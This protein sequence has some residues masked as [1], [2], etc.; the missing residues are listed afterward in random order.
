[1]PAVPFSTK[2]VAGL[3]EELSGALLEPGDPAY[4]DA[5]RVHNGLI[6]RHPALIARCRTVNDIAAA[7]RF[8]R[9]HGLEVAV[10]GGG[11]NVA[12]RATVD[13]GL[14][15][16]LSMMREVRVDPERRLGVAQGGVTWA[17]LTEATQGHGLATTG[18]V[19]SSTGVA[20][21]T[22]GGGWGWLQG[23]H[24]LSVDN[25]ESVEM[26]LADGTVVTAGEG[27]NPD[28][29]WAVRG[30]GA[31]FG[32]VASFTFRLHPVGPTVVGGMVLHPFEH[33]CEVLGF[34]RDV[35]ESLPDELTLGAG[36]IH[37][38]DGS[39][40]KLAAILAG[41]CGPV[42]EGLEA[43][44]PL[45]D[46]GSPVMDALG[47]MPYEDLNRMLDDAYP[48]GALNYWKSGFLSGL[49]DDAID[50]A[51]DAFARCPVPMGQ[52]ILEMWHGATR[53]VAPD[54]TAYPHRKGGHNVVVL[55]EWMDA[56]DTEAGI[57]WARETYAALGP[58]LTG[59]GYVNYMSEGDRAEVA[60]AYGANHPRLAAL[61]A[62]Y[63]PDNL[64]HLNHNIRP[65]A[66]A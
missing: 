13:G 44:Q 51:I 56:A 28:L 62:K 33:A 65:K 37:A 3:D 41:W 32:V 50:T 35:A 2:A 39:G 34:Y 49:G 66:R 46:H 17:E 43:V 5:R 20:G 36:L 21:L 12:G 14:V 52:V 1:M 45:K 9:D 15:I 31:N 8:G 61:K 42:E 7:V 30:A 64:F 10:R 4:D 40:A 16:D 48:R 19:V 27:E 55:S 54:A 26:V 63:D 59:G 24:G 47:P 60:S 53:R 58:F 38:P 11:H 23:K 6:D 18:G 25:L 57:D 29:F 22:L